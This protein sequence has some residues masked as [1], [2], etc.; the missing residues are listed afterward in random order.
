MPAL[1]LLD[2]RFSWPFVSLAFDKNFDV[3][4]GALDYSLV[5]EIVDDCT[6]RASIVYHDCVL[7][8]LV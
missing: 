7:N 1:V 5:V 8:F 6:V 3:A 4:L 2:L